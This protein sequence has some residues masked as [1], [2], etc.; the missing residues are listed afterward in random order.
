MAMKR[1]SDEKN[2]A[3]NFILASVCE[4][5][6][7]RFKK[8]LSGIVNLI[9]INNLNLLKDKLVQ[10][11][12]EMLLLD[13]ELP[14]LDGVRGVSELRKL[15]PGTKI[16]IFNDIASEENEWAM[17]KVGVR[18]CCLADIKPSSLKVM[19]DAVRNG[20][21][22]IRRTLTRRI[23]EQLEHLEEKPSKKMR[24]DF[25][26]LGLIDKLTQREYEIAAK[27]G[28]GES[29]KQIAY[30]LK[31]TERTVKAH[32]T[33]IFNKLGVSDRLKVALILSAE[34]RQ[35]RR[36]SQKAKDK[37]VVFQNMNL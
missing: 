20:E 13:Y 35:E 1:I 26:T 6:S 9:H 22:W 31:I 24:I 16:V 32:L 12:P 33:K 29:N 17:F 5:K 19:V 36:N 7:A 18:G 14:G 2:E 25:D 23:L 37:N 21:L 30:A 8:E 3:C 4:D 34:K 11:E 27:V 10:L 28:N 15:C